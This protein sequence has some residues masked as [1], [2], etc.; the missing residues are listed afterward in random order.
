M[1]LGSLSLWAV[2]CRMT[3]GLPVTQ[4][5]L[6]IHSLDKIN[7]TRMKNT[8]EWQEL[9]LFGLSC[10]VFL[11]GECTNFAPLRRF[12]LWF[13]FS[14][15]LFGYHPYFATNFIRTALG[16]CFLSLCFLRMIFKLLFMLNS[17][18]RV[19]RA[20]TLNHTERQQNTTIVVNLVA[21]II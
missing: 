8:W 16:W 5:W 6:Q 11:F 18:T 3:Q 14:L 13:I 10:L 21:N 17:V 19:N 2:M 20:V 4:W 1:F 12:R 15:L 9:L 7:W